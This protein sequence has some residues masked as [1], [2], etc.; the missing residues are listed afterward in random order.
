MGDEK[1]RNTWSRR[2]RLLRGPAISFVSLL[3]VLCLFEGF[4]RLIGKPVVFDPHREVLGKAWTTAVHRPS[5]VPGLDYEPVPGLDVSSGGKRLQTNSMG[6]RA[7]ELNKKKPADV[8][9]VAVLGDS[10]TFAWG[11]KRENTYPS[12]LERLLDK[13]SSHGVEV[14]NMG[15]SGYGSRDEVLLFLH[16]GTKLSPDLVIMQYFL[17]DPNIGP[18]QPL[19]AHYRPTRWWQHLNLTRLVKKTIWKMRIEELG[20]GDY[21][22]YL[23]NHPESWKSVTSAF[24][25]LGQW[26]S[27]NRVP[28]LLVIFPDLG[29]TSGN[30]YPYLDLHRKVKKA[31]RQQGFLVL[32][33]YPHFKRFPQNEL[34]LKKDNFHPSRKAHELA[35]R[36]IYEKLEKSFPPV[37]K[38][39]PTTRKA[40]RAGH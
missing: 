2:G 14:V 11:I 37:L 9:R 13:S 29:A 7:E 5:A 24:A 12:I 31:A 21:Y 8:F 26:S 4:L 22:R 35:A 39:P 27:Q 6:F 16:R 17:N 15:V 33:L 34:V 18:V 30:N 1:I 25:K 20:Q 19:A 3:L 36:R 40:E 28:V 10:F 23:H 38:T 32:D